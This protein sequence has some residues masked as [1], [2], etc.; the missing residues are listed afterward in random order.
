MLYLWVLGWWQSQTDPWVGRLLVVI[1]ESARL[2]VRLARS[3]PSAGLAEIAAGGGCDEETT[4]KLLSELP[5]R[6]RCSTIAVAVGLSDDIVAAVSAA[7]HRVFPPGAA[8]AASSHWHLAM[9]CSTGTASRR[10]HAA[11]GAGIETNAAAAEHRG[12]PPALLRGI[13]HAPHS[14]VAYAAAANPACP[15]AVLAAL[16]LSNVGLRETIAD[17][18]AC[19]PTVLAAVAADVGVDGSDSMLREAAATN[20]ACPPAVLDSLTRSLHED[21]A[22]RRAAAENP[23]CPPEGRARRPGAVTEW[24]QTSEL[25][26]AAEKESCPAEILEQLGVHYNY[27]V[28]CA[29]A[30]NLSCPPQLLASLA[31]N[32]DE[33]V[34]AA[35]AANVCL[36]RP[37]I[38]PLAW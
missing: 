30:S 9:R 24:E 1:A 27:W 25:V 26:A 2:L 13:C 21:P 16:A 5:T 4:L 6:G 32:D 11:L 37:S 38:T 14:N 34:R 36:E 15:P 33:D 22:L 28:R 12:C 35:A 31:T 29:V 20:S 7:R 18:P 19:P 23:S 10:W 17:N 3:V 8:A